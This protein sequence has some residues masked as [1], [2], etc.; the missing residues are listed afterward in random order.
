MTH[1]CNYYCFKFIKIK[2]FPGRYTKKPGGLTM[3]P[4][5][6]SISEIN[7]LPLIN[8]IGPFEQCI[9]VYN[10]IDFWYYMCIVTDLITLQY[11]RR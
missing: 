11:I 6:Y 3:G 9:T 8:L 5:D 10:L 2:I 1:H 4:G 7:D